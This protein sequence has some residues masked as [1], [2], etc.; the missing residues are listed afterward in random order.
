M[1]EPSIHPPVDT[2][3]PAEPPQ[4]QVS[5]VPWT[6]G[7]AA[8]VLA[9]WLVAALFVG[10]AV[11]IGFQ[12]VFPE[13]EA[14]A[15]SL[16]ITLLTLVAVVVG[17]VWSRYPGAAR[18][19]LGP[20]RPSAKAFGWGVGGGIVAIVV[21]AVGLGSLLE[22]LAHLSR[23]ELPQVQETFREIAADRAA[24]PLLVFGSVLVAPLAEELCFRGLLYS[25]LRKRFPLW[26]AMGLSGLAFGLTHFQTS[27][28]GYLLVLLIIMPLGMF[29]AY[30][31]ERTRTLLVPIVIH[32]VF[33]L[34]QVVLLIQ[35]QS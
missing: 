15:L 31:Y 19:L 6:I 4:P 2:A 5:D 25:A 7:D 22:Y 14:A 30:A 18:R 11:L 17:Y 1:S 16:P 26:P 24:A 12:Q 27:L 8:I 35:Q 21:F 28:D 13:T 34:F 9:I 3:P 29:L 20:A 10:G 33:N 23:G 32:A